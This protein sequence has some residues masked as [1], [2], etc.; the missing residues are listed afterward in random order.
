MILCMGVCGVWSDDKLT[1]D[2]LRHALSVADG[3]ATAFHIEVL[4]LAHK[5]KVVYAR[6][7][8]LHIKLEEQR[9]IVGQYVLY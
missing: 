7:S 3:K 2:T 4:R 9:K 6:Y 5:L 8:E 1:V